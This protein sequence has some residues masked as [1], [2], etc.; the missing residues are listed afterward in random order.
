MVRILIAD[1]EWLTRLEIKEMLTG[2]GYEVVGQA[3]SGRE[4]VELARDLRPDL[5]LMDV[6]MPGE[7]DG[8]AA[9]AM[10]KAQQNIPIIFISGYGDPEYIERAK[11]IEP[12][13]YVMKP[14][15]EREIRA[16]VEIT[17]YRREMELKLRQANDQ[18]KQ[19]NRELERQMSDRKETLDRFLLLL[20][21][22]DAAVYVADM[23]TYEILFI[24]KYI[25]NLFGNRVGD[26][27]W[28][29]FHDGQL[30]PCEFCTNNRLI[31]ASGEPTGPI[32]WDHYNPKAGGWWEIR[33]QAIKWPDG[34]MVRLEIA[35][36]IS[37]R[38]QAEEN[39]RISQERM[40][41]II[42]FLPDAT[43]VIDT[44]GKVVAWNHAIEKMTGIRA[45]DM[46][47][48]A[49]FQYAI[50]FYGK[51][52]PILIDLVSRW[53][54]EAEAAY[55]YIKKE[56]EALVSETYNCLVKPGGTLWNKAS[57]LY[58]ENGEVTGAIESIRDITERKA[59]EEALRQSEERYRSLFD[60]AKSAI[61]LT[62][63]GG[64][65]VD[66]NTYALNLFGCTKEEMLGMNFQQ[67]YVDPDDGHRFRKEMEENGSL[68]EFSTRL[69]RS[70]GLE[71]DCRMDVVNRYGEMG[72]VIGYQGI[73][74]DVTESNRL[75]M[76]L[77]E[78]RKTEAIA[79]LAGGIAHQFNNA[80]T[81]IIGNLDLLEM[82]YGQDDK[83]M[84]ALKHM[85][86]SSRRMARLTRQ[87]LAYAREGKYQVRVL[88][89]PAFVLGT[90]PLIE[91]TLKPDVHVGTD[92]PEDLSF[93]KADTTQ[94]QMVLSAL[95]ANA[96]EAMDGPGRIRIWARN[97]NLDAPSV[98]GYPGLAPGPYVCLSVED[99]GKGM[100]EETRKRIFD[101]FFTTHFL[102]RGLG[103]AA[104]YGIVKNH[105]GAIKVDSAQG[106]GTL[107]RIYL[108]AV[109]AERREEGARDGKAPG[110]ETIGDEKTVLVIEDDELVMDM[111]QTMLGMLGYRVL[112]AATGQE[113]VHTAR[114]FDGGIDFALL[115][116]KL[117]DMSGIQVYPLIMAAR[118][119]LKVVVCSG[120][121]IDGPAREILNSGAH[122]FIQKPFSLE[123]LNEKLRQVLQ[124]Q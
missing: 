92:L 108:P 9:G 6:V 109:S 113:A 124:K 65:L 102:G 88:S 116:I 87:L 28:Q 30:G 29:A 100:D 61:V 82:E 99:T 85:K 78:A 52:R 56:G 106:K 32:V 20:D 112:K 97:I 15:D 117:P 72:N 18:L 77:Q 55:Q 24:N 111:T 123:A 42:D 39:L 98:E 41:Q 44:N 49:D 37:K 93:I 69:R 115:D 27:C 7:T 8:I 50:P 48:K 22:L 80:L 19:I 110:V 21:S 4:A 13:G 67:F 53:D 23:E 57:L 94:L 1:D 35:L 120:Y 47:G 63:R 59:Y 17:L 71:M 46:L 86:A 14:F 90:I 64:D 60:H 3:E 83:M 16:F 43:F 26:L 54:K 118:P 89:L 5:I 38:K 81:P 103:M 62:T 12:F 122:G 40:R 105:G 107:V 45:K 104:V 74:R 10:I 114:T 84:K 76:Q 96:N 51:R 95:I 31:A 11:Y 36:D 119:D 66:A 33:D 58:A 34:R 2:L 101:P 68:Q 73:I 91:H 79:T 70:D 121:S 25:K 75:Q